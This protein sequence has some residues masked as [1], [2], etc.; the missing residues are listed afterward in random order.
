MRSSTLIYKAS[1]LLCQTMKI[2]VPSKSQTIGRLGE[3]FVCKLFGDRLIP[4]FPS[5]IFYSR[6]PYDFVIWDNVKV[7]V[8]CSYPS[9]DGK[10]TFIISHNENKFDILICVPLN[11]NIFDQPSF[12][13][14]PKKDIS[15]LQGF[16]ITNGNKKKFKKYL[17]NFKLID[18]EI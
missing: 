3:L 13:I 5:C 2:E 9:E 7:E 4:F 12:Y 10:H 17:N 14:I 11:Y 8:K 18:K 6:S 1:E 15:H 16:H